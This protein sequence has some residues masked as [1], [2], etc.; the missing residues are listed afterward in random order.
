[1]LN[2]IILSNFK[3]FSDARSLELAPIT[4]I[5][6]PNSSGKST[7]I[8]SLL[9]LKQT[10][11]TPQQQ[12][13][14]VAS[15]SCIDLNSYKSIV[16]SHDI[17]K[18]IFLSF[19]FHLTLSGNEY[20]DIFSEAPVFGSNDI[21]EIQFTY[22][23]TDTK[24]L[25][26]TTSF[27]KAFNYKV[28]SKNNSDEK[29]FLNI[30]KGVHD[31]TEELKG[32][33]YATEK[34]MRSLAAFMNKRIE[35]ISDFTGSDA[36][37]NL[38]GR[39]IRENT[40]KIKKDISLPMDLS[41]ITAPMINDYLQRF[42][43]EIMY[44]LKSIKYLGPLRTNPQRFYVSV[45]DDAGK[46]KGESNLGAELKEA[47]KSAINKINHWFKE[48]EIPYSISLHNL[49]TDY[50]G[51]IV[52]IV[53]TDNRTN[54]TVTP[55]DVG[56]GIGQVLPIITEAI[57][58][59]N[60][61]ICVEQP[62]IHLHPR[63]Q[64]H[65]AD[66]FIDSV[67]GPNKEKNGYFANQWIIETHSEALM[68]RLQRRIREKKISKKLIKVYYVSADATGAQALELPLDDEGD[69]LVHW[70]DGFFEERLHELFGGSN[71]D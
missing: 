14:F 9:A 54:T 4:L 47:G 42:S 43:S 12:A 21:R 66:L 22:S 65:L 50:S 51:D 19:S 46:M 29:I 16:H 31:Y 59:K 56:F 32:S 20:V 41:S 1:M 38:C 70:P 25:N 8:Q 3:S 69:F 6:G 40:Y 24:P 58:S 28:Y 23:H 49:G 30:E 60:N 37:K 26:N 62:E 53:L 10:L 55:K 7:I 61:V 2:E 71:A 67:I 48:F 36:L 45:K 44:Q 27:L 13:G 63:L 11:M 64:A 35:R 18:D 34:S 39:A 17:E 52:S 5:F 57:I 33:Y 68:L 15:G